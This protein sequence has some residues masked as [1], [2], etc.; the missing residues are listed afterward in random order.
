MRYPNMYHMTGLP[1]WMGFG[2]G[3]GWAGSTP[4]GIGPGAEYLMAGQW[5]TP[6]M[7]A[8]WQAMQMGASPMM[9][10]G[11]APGMY[12]YGMSPMGMWGQP[13]P[14]AQLEMLRQEAEMLQAELD[15]I[16]NYVAE[17]EKQ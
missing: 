6:Q 11:F 5:P 16:N 7:A 2:Y 9:G 8:A 10:M 12:G 15:E 13:D 4:M 17:F 14:Q 3:P 1:P